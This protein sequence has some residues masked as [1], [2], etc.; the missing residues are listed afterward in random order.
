MDIYDNF[1]GDVIDAIRGDDRALERLEETKKR[2]AR[3]RTVVPD[4]SCTY[5]K[6]ESSDE[7][8]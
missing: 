2:A 7:E 4:E 6:M 3:E 1:L 5:T 8:Q